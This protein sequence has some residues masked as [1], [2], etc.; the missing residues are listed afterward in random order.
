M[1]QARLVLSGYGAL[2]TMV[3]ASV[4]C[5]ETGIYDGRWEGLPVGLVAVVLLDTLVLWAFVGL[6]VELLPAAPAPQRKRNEGWSASSAA[7]SVG[8]SR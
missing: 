4:F 2:M 6:A 8:A 1:K 7:D 3:L 5:C